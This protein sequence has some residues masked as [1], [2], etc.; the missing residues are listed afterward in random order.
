MS[1]CDS[2][3]QRRRE[4]KR[5]PGQ[6]LQPL[7][8]VSRR[9]ST[10][11]EMSSD[12]GVRPEVAEVR[13][14]ADRGLRRAHDAAEPRGRPARRTERAGTRGGEPSAGRSAAASRRTADSASSSS[15]KLRSSNFF[16][17]DESQRLGLHPTRT[18][19]V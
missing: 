12:A 9:V 16:L 8:A 11:A 18:S 10:A 7:L 19:Y 6:V 4:R 17:L 1:V 14:P 5:A 2:S 13:G 15:Q 3:V